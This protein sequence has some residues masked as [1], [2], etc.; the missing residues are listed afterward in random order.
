MRLYAHC[1]IQSRNSVTL[2]GL[3]LSENRSNFRIHSG[4]E[5][6]FRI[7][8]VHHYILTAY[9]DNLT[10]KKIRLNENVLEIL[11]N[12]H[13]PSLTPHITYKTPNNFGLPA[14]GMGFWVF[15]DS[16]SNI[17]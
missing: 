14:Y 4:N 15:I 9:Q 16:T 17:C 7:D 13:L 6:N 10:S 3:N 8:E 5:S 2:F 1:A 11:K 12:D